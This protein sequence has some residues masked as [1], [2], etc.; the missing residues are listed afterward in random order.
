MVS[1]GPKPLLSL[2][3]PHMGAPSTPH[4][5]G[6]NQLWDLW[7]TKG[8]AVVKCEPHS[9]NCCPAQHIYSLYQS[10]TP[11]WYYVPTE[12]I[13]WWPWRDSI[14]FCIPGAP[15]RTEMISHPWSLG[16]SIQLPSSEQAALDPKT[17]MH[18]L[19]HPLWNPMD[20]HLPGEQ[21]VQG[22]PLS[23]KLQQHG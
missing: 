1:K 19:L 22:W 2:W 13:P 12:P 11:L 18:P 20:Q 14:P 23:V 4:S 3:D 10:K 5:T 16:V 17:H 7:S 15:K 21:E 9:P 6:A 8:E